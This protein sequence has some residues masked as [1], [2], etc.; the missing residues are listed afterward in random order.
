MP[1]PSVVLGEDTLI[2]RTVGVDI[3]SATS[4]L[5]VS[6]LTL[7]RRGNRYETTDRSVIYASDLM[8]TPFISD[9]VIDSAAL[10]DFFTS[11]YAKAGVRPQDVDTGAVI[12]TGVALLRRNAESVA[13]IFAE[14]SGRFVSVAAGD[15]IEAMLAAHGSG[16][17]D[18]SL[19]AGVV[20]NVDVGGGT[21]K[22]SL[23]IDGRAEQMTALDVGARLIAWDEDGVVRRLEP[24]GKILADL[25]GVSVALGSRLPEAGRCRL[26]HCG[27]EAI[28][29]AASGRWSEPAVKRLLRG[30]PL[31]AASGRDV[32][33]SGG[34]ARYLE[35][36]ETRS[37]GDLGPYLAQ[38]LRDAMNAR[39]LALEVARSTIRATVIGA[40]QFTV[41]VSGTTIHVS[42]PQALP[43]RNVPV[44]EVPA[45]SPDEA[46]LAERVR[47]A[48]AT[49][50]ADD[51]ALVL[52]LPWN[53][54]ATFAAL[55]EFSRQ[56]L[57][58]VT[59]SGRPVGCLV[60]ALDS[61]V[62]RLVGAHL[63]EEC[64]YSESL[65]V[66]DGVALERFDFIDVGDYLPNS[67]SLPVTIKSLAF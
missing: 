17:V 9:E 48:I 41:Q 32:L 19:S 56:V 36:S 50:P 49:S 1:V 54:S 25:A 57:A 15:E 38:A 20:T 47:T 3:G 35:G 22:L 52:S 30:D 59:S 55:N 40:S 10:S 12:L 43:L 28:A 26:A 6:D 2:L 34:M 39:G 51:R 4:Q 16:A 14:Y 7:E 61:D 23:C 42:G 65:V 64:G 24:A 31:P 5:V 37:Y 33:V 60:L 58:G 66:I 67:T 8:L 44:A 13:G 27:A 18:A 46:G 62:A 11:Q 53:G 29:D 21:T 63:V 45:V